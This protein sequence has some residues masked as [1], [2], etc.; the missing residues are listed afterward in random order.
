MPTAQPGRPLPSRAESVVGGQRL[1]WLERPGEDPPVVLLHGWG[2][3][4]ATFG[5]LLRLSRSP[6][7]LLALD[8]PGFGESPIGPGGWTTAAYSRLVRDWLADRGGASFSLL[9]HSYGGSISLRIAAE[10]G[11]RPDRLLLCSASGVRPAAGAA[12]GLRVRSFKALRA[13]AGWLPE[14][15]SGRA[16]EWLRQRFGSADYRAASPQLRP[17]LVAAVREDLSSQAGQIAV[18]TLVI[19]GARDPELPLEPDGR[20]LAG[21]IPPAELVVFEASGHFPFLDEPG[22]FALVFDAFMDAKL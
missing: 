7:R 8:L 5:P 17:T 16:S 19:W 14:P 20:R 21:L 4:A 6:R 11:P 2:A 10:P 1:S 12:P 22:R 13:L 3:S 15:A 9:G 18:P